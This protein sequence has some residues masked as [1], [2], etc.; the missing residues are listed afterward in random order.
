MGCDFGQIIPAKFCSAHALRYNTLHDCA[1]KIHLELFYSK[2][3][4]SL[5][6]GLRS[7]P[8]LDLTLSWICLIKA[9]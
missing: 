4:S 6:S 7:K 5:I 9:R 2:F 3:P 8:N 1:L